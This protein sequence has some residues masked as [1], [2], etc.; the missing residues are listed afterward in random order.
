[1]ILFL[2]I[3]AEGDFACK[4]LG[5]F[6]MPSIFK[7]GD[8][9]LGAIFP[10]F[11][12]EESLNVVFQKEPHGG[13]CV[14]FD[15]RAYRWAQVMMFTIKEINEDQSLLPNITL[16]YAIFDSCAS[17]TNTLRAALTLVSGQEGTKSAAECRPPICA[18]IA[19]SGSSQSAAAAGTL[20]PF[21]VPMV[22]Y[23]STCAC[24]SDKL[25]YPTFF[26]TI[27]SDYH[28]A[29]AL[30]SLVKRFGW[31][32]IGA[33]QADN[34]YGRNGILSFTEEVKKFGVCIAFIGTVLRT[35]PRSKILEVVE[36][37][38]QSTVR[39]ILAFVPEGDLYPLM[40]E[41]VM[42]NITGIQ[43]I[44]SE[45]WITA[46]RPSTIEIFHSFGGAIGFATR[47]MAMPKLKDFLVNINPL[48]VPQDPFVRD[49][50]KTI[51]GCDLGLTRE[52][53]TSTHILAKSKLCTGDEKLDPA[54]VFFNVTQL[55]VSY[56]VYK[57]V[58]AIAHALHNFIFCLNESEKNQR[59]VCINTS[60]IKPRQVSDHL[61][62]VN[63]VNSFGE[64]VFFDENGDP[65]PSYEIINWQ[66]RDG[67]VQHV[68]VGHFITSAHGYE[69]VIEEEN[70]IWSTGKVIPKAV[71]TEI[72]PTGSRKA[73][74]KGKPTC[75]FDCI[76]CADGTI[77][78][79]TG[80]TD[81]IP[82]PLEYWSNKAKDQCIPKNI[83]FLSYNDGMGIALT[84]VSLS[85]VCLAFATIVVFFNFKTTPIVK[86]NNSEL[87][88]LLLFSL[89]LCFLC[90]LTFIGEPTI[91][92]CMLRHT[93]FGI[94][95][96]LCISCVLGKTIVV[97]TAFRATLPNNNMARK[98]GPVQQRIIV[99]SCTTVQICICVLWLTLNPPFPDR[100][101][102]QDDKKIILEC[103]TGSETA[104]YAV[105]GYIG[106]LSAVC[107]VLA[108][109]ARKLPDNFNEA[110]F[111]TFSMLIF[112]T[113]WL[114]FIPA[115]VSSPGKYTVAVEIFAILS[116]TFGLL[117]CIFAPKCYIILIKPEK[118]TRNNVMGKLRTKRL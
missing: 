101:F 79:T 4:L 86:A 72:C 26:R 28:Q 77:A 82:C 46:A 63:F 93:A 94:T 41:L 45:A 40:Q 51:V 39:V 66:L 73:Q 6:G 42:Q 18:V 117:F 83:E 56:N 108:F 116:S 59:K 111:I 104:F 1:M 97:V 61:K 22:S 54:H 13:N 103:N 3:V 105:L 87:S 64:A 67:E 65:P 11:N 90:P 68:T 23:F 31:S 115:Y 107:L 36:T 44:A 75:C 35:Y 99:F 33:I 34:D 60:Q 2:K 112:C 27:P 14:G 74:M 24:L 89:L 43:W 113:V 80:A 69:L 78:N 109:L 98:F 37:I 38:K 9:M 48:A 84:V 19:E 106:L 50:W 21:G 100:T 7:Q 52:S 118:N 53:S 70:I 62:T 8:I 71:C 16:G 110:K 47:K 15:L 102:K 55:R 96:A 58:Y 49:F 85:G 30:A 10:L 95:F 91:W 12:K 25:K 57:A 29:K 114:T 81:C 88:F 5:N 92:S 17:P 32:W 76:P 20:G